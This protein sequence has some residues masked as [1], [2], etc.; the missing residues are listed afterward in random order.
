[1]EFSE[2]LLGLFANYY[3]FSCCIVI[4][5]W[6][7]RLLCWYIWSSSNHKNHKKPGPFSDY[8]LTVLST[9]SLCQLSVFFDDTFVCIVFEVGYWITKWRDE[10]SRC[11]CCLSDFNL[12]SDLKSY[13]IKAI[14]C[15]YDK[16]FPHQ[17]S[18]N[19]TALSRRV[20]KLDYYVLHCF[21]IR[22][23]L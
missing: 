2:Q 7:T 12:K 19:S 1:M 11:Y 5:L 21:F 3:S 14:S 16:L 9:E 8:W 22:T 23:I 6:R 13:Q 17:I 20:L 15:E 10:A 18:H 4:W